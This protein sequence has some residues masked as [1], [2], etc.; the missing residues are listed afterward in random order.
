MKTDLILCPVDNSHNSSVAF[1]VISRL[2]KRGDKVLLLHVTGSH[3]APMSLQDSWMNRA[4]ST[5][6][7]RIL[8]EQDVDVEHLT[9]QG[10]PAEIITTVARRKKVDLIVMGTH[11]RTG[12]S[13]LFMGSVARGVLADAPC[14]VI[15]VRPEKIVEA[16]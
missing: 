16:S 11:G 1:D 12:L 15:T 8:T 7:D 10:D 2:V 6:R 4:E 13:S 5:L 14:A 3:D 9:L